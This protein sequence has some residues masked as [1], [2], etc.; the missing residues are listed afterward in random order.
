MTGCKRGC[1]YCYAEDMFNRFDKSFEPTFHPE[2][3]EEPYKVTKPSKIF[4]GSVCDLFA[5][6]T[7]RDWM[8]KVLDAIDECP[9][10]H[11]WQLL[12]KSPENIPIGNWACVKNI[13]LGATVT[14][15]DNIANIAEIRNR[16]AKVHFISFEPL[17]GRIE[18]LDLRGI[19]WVIVGA[20]TGSKKVKLQFDW[21]TPILDECGDKNIPLF[22]KNNLRQYFP[23]LRLIQNF[24]EV[25]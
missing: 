17:L 14:S 4:V 3:L 2:R 18:N 8:W 11:N 19:D 9:V 13:W 6:W 25:N 24:P 12:T 1:W 20:L 7:D 16:Q 21:L 10:P 15:K 23:D 22:M 5:E